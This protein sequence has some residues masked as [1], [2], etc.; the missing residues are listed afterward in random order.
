MVAA[1]IK[2]KENRMRFTKLSL[3]ACIGLAACGPRLEVLDVQQVPQEERSKASAVRIYRVGD[4]APA[5]TVYIG[6][7]EATS[8]KRLMTDPPPSSANATEQLKV[9]TLRMGGNMVTDYACDDSGTDALGTNCW[10]S[11]TCGGNAVT[12]PEHAHGN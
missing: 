7:V 8:C 6:P 5:K 1:G 10:A 3:L 9:K 2:G 12:T 11:V 4:N